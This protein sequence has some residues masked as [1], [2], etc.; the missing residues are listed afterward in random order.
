VSAPVTLGWEQSSERPVLLLLLGHG[1]VIE[2]CP[3][4]E[5]EGDLGG[6]GQV[7][8]GSVTGDA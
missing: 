7:G 6:D 1:G 2:I 3:V 5:V 4:G 8:H